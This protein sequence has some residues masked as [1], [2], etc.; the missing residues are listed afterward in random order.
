MP[1]YTFSVSGDNTRDAI[2][3][4]SAESITDLVPVS[5]MQPIDTFYINLVW[6][7]GFLYVKMNNSYI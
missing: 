7:L 3:Q 1:N 5:A 2:F 6:A 4:N